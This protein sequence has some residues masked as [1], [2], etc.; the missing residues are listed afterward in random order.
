ML[1]RTVGYPSTS[2]ASCSDSH[3]PALHCMVMPRVAD[4]GGVIMIGRLF[5][6]FPDVPLIFRRTKSET[7]LP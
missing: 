5:F 1:W 3:S 7:D 6:N 4:L 2:W